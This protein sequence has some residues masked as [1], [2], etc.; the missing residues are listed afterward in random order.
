MYPNFS[1]LSLQNRKNTDAT[2]HVRSLFTPAHLQEFHVFQLCV[3]LVST[4]NDPN[5]KSSSDGSPGYGHRYESLKTRKARASEKWCPPAA[6]MH[7]E[8]AAG[9]Q[10]RS[11]GH[12]STPQGGVALR[13][14]YSFRDFLQ[15]QDYVHARQSGTVAMMLSPRMGPSG[16]WRYGASRRGS[17]RD[18]PRSEIERLSETQTWCEVEAEAE[19][20]AFV[21]CSRSR[22][23]RSWV[24]RS[25]ALPYCGYGADG[26]GGGTRF[27]ARSRIIIHLLPIVLVSETPPGAG[28]P[29]AR[30]AGL[31]KRADWM[32][33]CIAT[34][35]VASARFGCGGH[36]AAEA[37]TS[38]LDAEGVSRPSGLSSDS[39]RYLRSPCRVARSVAV[40]GRGDHAGRCKRLGGSLAQFLVL[41][42]PGLSGDLSLSRRLAAIS[43]RGYFD[44]RR[45]LP[46][47]DLAEVLANK[48]R[49]TIV[50]EDA[51]RRGALMSRQSQ[52]ARDRQDVDGGRTEEGMFVASGATEEGDTLAGLDSGEIR[53]RDRS[54]VELSCGPVSRDRSCGRA[55][56]KGAGAVARTGATCGL[57]RKEQLGVSTRA[58][59]HVRRENEVEMGDDVRLRLLRAV[60]HDGQECDARLKMHTYPLGEGA[61]GGGRCAGISKG[62]QRSS[63]S[64]GVRLALKDA[65]H[66]QRR[67]SC[68]R[69]SKWVR[70]ADT[71]VREEEVLSQKEAPFVGARVCTRECALGL[72]ERGVINLRMVPVDD[73][74]H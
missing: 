63:M 15:V 20:R 25:L 54:G 8:E 71:C 19:A 31:S 39:C 29:R 52:D 9:I 49:G 68:T 41:T 67:M 60:E 38:T 53:A 14:P 34:C 51:K 17:F 1:L 26:G 59:A 56:L 64:L 66:G 30:Y 40:G 62:Q 21:A 55:V 35:G 24:G 50:G 58:G 6:G 43:I 74:G 28:T 37:I 36:C 22:M 10:W 72:R 16:R 13:D 3:L 11:S 23:S 32:R 48:R 7:P 73:E 33:R 44:A 69:L 2:V 45:T 4:G 65:V 12:S 46:A 5:V 47:G 70:V 18:S 57:D 61:A 42:L 27:A